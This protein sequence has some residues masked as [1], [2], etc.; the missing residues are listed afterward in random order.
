MRALCD[1][2][3]VAYGSSGTQTAANLSDAQ[4]FCDAWY[5]KEYSGQYG[6][7]AVITPVDEDDLTRADIAGADLVIFG[8]EESSRYIGRMCGDVS[9]PFNLPVQILNDRIVLGGE[10]YPIPTYGLWMTYPNPL[11]PDRLVVVGRK[12]YKFGLETG[13]ILKTQES[14]PWDWPDYVVFNM[15]GGYAA[16]GYFDR[17]WKL[18]DADAPQTD[19]SFVAPA[20]EGTSFSDATSSITVTVDV[21]D[22]LGAVVTGLDQSDF[23]LRVDGEALAVLSW[24]GEVAGGRYECSLDISALVQITSMDLD[25]DQTT[26][27][28]TVEVVRPG[29]ASPVVGIGR[30]RFMISP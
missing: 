7:G 8:T 16:S 10:T 12:V 24:D 29:A 9:L 11:A 5:D 22:E 13:E 20:T 21:K 26:Y 23:A 2:F 28:L 18:P 17:D 4:D 3:I 19:V 14:W 27:D 15:G 6:F 30:T 1:R 25:P